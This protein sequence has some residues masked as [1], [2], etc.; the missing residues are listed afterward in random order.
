[1]YCSSCGVDSVEGL[2]YCKRCGANIAA[3]AA[4]P[5][6][7]PVPLIVTFLM[8]IG[9][10]FALGM[11]VPSLNA[12]EFHSLGFNNR[13]VMIM[14]LAVMGLT[15]AVIGML[16]WL[17]LRLVG[18]QQASAPPRVFESAPREVERPQLAAPPQSVG[19]VT[20]STTRTLDKRKYDTPSSLG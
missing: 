18:V 9:F 3:D 13:D 11:A 1:V 14:G 6:K 7:L 5:R 16:V 8:I 20:E 15:I 2:K 4:P 10:V 19:S 12:G 17:L